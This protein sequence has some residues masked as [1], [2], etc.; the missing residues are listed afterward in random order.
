MADKERDDFFDSLWPGYPDVMWGGKKV[1]EK[2]IKGYIGQ[3]WLFEGEELAMV[4]EKS[5]WDKA[6]EGHSLSGP[7]S[8]DDYERVIH[9]R[10]RRLFDDYRG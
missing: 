8:F 4:W 5:E 2:E 9:R 6:K 7:L 10:Y 3:V 1:Y